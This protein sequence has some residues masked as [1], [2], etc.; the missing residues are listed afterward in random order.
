M[1]FKEKIDDLL[2]QSIHAALVEK[3]KLDPVGK[4]DADIDNDGDVDASDEYLH[5]RRK[6]I[7]KAMAKESF[8]LSEATIDVDYVGSEETAR[9]QEKRFGVRISVKKNGTALVSGDPKNVWKFAVDHYDS[10]EDAKDLE[11]GLYRMAKKD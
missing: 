4:A 1:S 9:K 6:A 7:K 2:E 11:P 10:A 3:K 5:N 8:E